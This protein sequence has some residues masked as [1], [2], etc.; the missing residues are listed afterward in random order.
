MAVWFG[1]VAIPPGASPLA[2]RAPPSASLRVA[3]G[4]GEQAY[5]FTF[6]LDPAGRGICRWQGAGPPDAPAVEKSSGESAVETPELPSLA[7][8]VLR[9]ASTAPMEP[10][11]FPPDSLIGRLEISSENGRLVT[12][13]MADEEQ[14][15]TA[16]LLPPDELR[17]FT[18][19]VYDSCEGVAR[20]RLRP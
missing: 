10:P 17:G 8:G 12:F 13:F 7:D 2:R 5:E 15:R 4:I 9:A 20:R 6:E 19:A 1:D 14:A 18:Q 16:D 11:S 3:G